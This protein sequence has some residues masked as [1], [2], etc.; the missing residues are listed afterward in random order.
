GAI[1][2]RL[3]KM[4]QFTGDFFIGARSNRSRFGFLDYSGALVGPQP[5]NFANVQ[6]P[7]DFHLGV[8][9]N[10]PNGIKFHGDVVSTNYLAYRG[11]NLNGGGVS[12]PN[13]GL[14]QDTTLYEANIVIP[15]GVSLL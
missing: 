15:V 9:A 10:L 4:I 13:A 6:T 12:V 14:N 7:H 11:A 3:D 5:S 8:H 1:E 2:R